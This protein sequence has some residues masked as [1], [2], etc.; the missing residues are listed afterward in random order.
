VRQEDIVIIASIVVVVL[1][2]VLSPLIY[3]QFNPKIITIDSF[4]HAFQRDGMSV[5][6]VKTI[7][8]ARRSARKQKWM[9]VNGAVVSVFE[10][11]TQDAVTTNSH[12]G[13]KEDVLAPEGPIHG[14]SLAIPVSTAS[15][16]LYL[17]MVASSDDDLRARVL[18]VFKR[19]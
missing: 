15:N 4:E 3:R 10:Y 6:N 14:G 11:T 5:A 1:L 16:G 13:E 18:S 2:I 7:Y 8:P 9:T 19:I 12:F 17:L